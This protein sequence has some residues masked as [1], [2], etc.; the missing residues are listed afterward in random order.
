MGARPDISKGL[1]VLPSQF[2][3]ADLNSGH[4]TGPLHQPNVPMVL[5]LPHGESLDLGQNARRH[6]PYFRMSDSLDIWTT[7]VRFWLYR[8]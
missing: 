8:P 1:P 5:T 2:G 7:K 4:P 3:Q 6:L